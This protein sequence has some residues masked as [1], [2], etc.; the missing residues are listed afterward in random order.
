[1]VMTTSGVSGAARSPRRNFPAHQILTLFGDYWWGIP[2]AIPTGAL[3]AGLGDLGVNEP[4]A[5]AAISRL[6]DQDLL[7]MSKEGRR[8]SHALSERGQRVVR[9]EA[10]WLTRFGC[11]DV[12]WDGLWSVIAF[13]IPEAQRAQRHVARTRLRWLGYAPLY[14]GV[15]ISPFDTREQAEQVL[16]EAGVPDVTSSRTALRMSD[17]AGPSR[18]W[19]MEEV[20]QSYLEFVAR[21]DELA[22]ELEPLP[23]FAART[24]LMLAWQTFR[25]NDPDHP[26]EILPVDWPRRAARLAFARA[27][28]TLG[29]PAEERM[30]MHIAKISPELATHVTVQRLSI[31]CP[32]RSRD[33]GGRETSGG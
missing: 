28:N 19:N 15:W 11:S 6:V 12:E 1:M 7:E 31:E 20:R 22:R 13:T 21:A 26:S 23:A 2:E 30:R 9:D 33:H 14:D 17:P 16:G 8:T 5:R 29:G 10:R 25:Q 4:A 18:A 27:Y 3:L 32:P 24:G